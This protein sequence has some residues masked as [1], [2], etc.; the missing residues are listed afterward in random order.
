MKNKELIKQRK[1]EKH[2][3][4]KSSKIYK[5]ASHGSK[6]YIERIIQNSKIYESN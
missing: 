5:T 3:K 2:K 4:R 1:L 6:K